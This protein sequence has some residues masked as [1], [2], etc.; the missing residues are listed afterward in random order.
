[1][2]DLPKGVPMWT[3]DLRQEVHR[4]GNP[5]LPEQPSGLHNALEDARHLKAMDDHVLT[6]TAA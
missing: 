1:M 4:L 5:E 3:N 2:I 6:T